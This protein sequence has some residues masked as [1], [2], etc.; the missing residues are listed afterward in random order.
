LTVVL[1]LAA[2]GCDNPFSPTDDLEDARRTWERQGIQSYSLTVHQDCFCPEDVRGPFRVRVVSGVVVSVTDPATGAPRSASAF[3]PLTVEAL[4][5][6]VQQAIDE[7]VRE[8]DV[9]YDP[10]LGY[11]REIEINLSQQAVDAG[12]VIQAS[13]LVR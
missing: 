5:D 3:T 6:R 8:L 2:A 7:G 9:R 1:A 11:P 13:D 4:F 10:E 12:I